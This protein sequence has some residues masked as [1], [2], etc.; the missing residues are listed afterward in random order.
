MSTDDKIQIPP[1]ER[2]GVNAVTAAAMMGC[3][4]STFFRRIREGLYPP[5]ARGGWGIRTGIR[6]SPRPFGRG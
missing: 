5:A 3:G 6:K 4:R 1:W 2:L